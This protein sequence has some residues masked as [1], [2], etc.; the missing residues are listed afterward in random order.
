MARNEK[1]R[2]IE[3]PPLNLHFFPESEENRNCDAVVLAF[4]EFEAIRLVDRLKLDHREASEIMGIS[5]PTFTRL[6]EKA[7][8]HMAQF[9]V[10]GLPLDISGGSI[11]FASHV[12]CCRYCRAPFKWDGEGEAVC[13]R[14]GRSD[15]LHAHASCG[16]SC[17]CCE[18][19]EE[20]YRS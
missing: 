19:E 14:C 8:G 3:A 9:L 10:E 1:I 20:D 4:D 18:K 12:F 16:G 2:S 11:K 13:P 7:R 17:V 6:L 15:A 5:R